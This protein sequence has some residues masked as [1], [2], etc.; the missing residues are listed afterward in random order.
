[1]PKTDDPMSA[2]QA[3]G[4]LSDAE[5]A[6]QIRFIESEDYSELDAGLALLAFREVQRYRRSTPPAP[7]RRED[8]RP[9]ET[10]PKGVKLL[11]GYRNRLGKWRTITGYYCEEQTMESDSE[12]SGFAPAGWYEASETHEEIMQTDEPP[13]HWQPLPAPPADGTKP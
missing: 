6:E 4:T 2:D 8:W 11:L 3:T 10:A 12:D 5:I 13:T 9:I 1:M 7:S